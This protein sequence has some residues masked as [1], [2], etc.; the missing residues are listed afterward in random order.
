M[1]IAA[2]KKLTKEYKGRLTEDE[3]LGFLILGGLVFKSNELSI[4]EVDLMIKLS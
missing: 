1:K 3:I 2:I 4:S